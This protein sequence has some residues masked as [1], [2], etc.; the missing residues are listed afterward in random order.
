MMARIFAVLSVL[1][2][3]GVL[4]S[5][6]LCLLGVFPLWSSLVAIALFFGSLL[7]ALFLR[8]GE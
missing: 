8:E 7:A 3:A 6:W 5:M 1:F 2:A 4:A